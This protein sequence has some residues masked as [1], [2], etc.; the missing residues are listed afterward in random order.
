MN[1]TTKS[2]LFRKRILFGFPNWAQMQN[3]CQPVTRAY[4]LGGILPGE[5]IYQR[6]CTAPR[7]STKPSP[8]GKLTVSLRSKLWLVKLIIKRCSSASL[9][10]EGERRLLCEC[11]VEKTKRNTKCRCENSERAKSISPPSCKRKR[12]LYKTMSLWLPE[13]GS[14]QWHHD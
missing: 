12:T 13:L 9:L 8:S 4:R 14:N 10:A 6:L 5:E 11:F 7:V 1:N 3:I 2:A